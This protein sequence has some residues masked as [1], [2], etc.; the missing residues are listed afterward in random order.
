MRLP[1]GKTHYD[2]LRLNQTATARDIKKSFFALSKEFHPDR[3]IS[4]SHDERVAARRKFELISAAYAVLGNTERRREYD[5]SLRN[6]DHESMS[7]NNE[8]YRQPGERRQAYSGMNRTRRSGSHSYNSKKQP[9]SS[10]PTNSHNTG[11][12]GGYATGMNNDVPHFDYEKYVQQQRKY[13]MFRLQRLNSRNK[14][15]RSPSYSFSAESGSYRSSSPQQSFTNS[16]ST[17]AR[18]S[19]TKFGE[20]TK[21]EETSS[22]AKSTPPAS[23]SNTGFRP[24]TARFTVESHPLY[25][26]HHVK[27]TRKQEA[28]KANN[29]LSTGGTQRSHDSRM[30]N[31][32][33]E[34]RSAV[35][36]LVILSAFSVTVYTSMVAFGF[37][38]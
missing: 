35:K 21:E 13:E 29:E 6:V 10:Y 33:T 11:L 27:E 37:L 20:N 5:L 1:R 32:E 25:S 3:T 4:Q 9:E 2:A 18:S 31:P 38:N 8:Y 22:T 15:E 28:M 24:N 23:S 7:S 17:G 30:R 26:H 34:I 14:F 12:G 16:S 36:N 19:S